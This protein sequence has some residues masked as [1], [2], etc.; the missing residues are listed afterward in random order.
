MDMPLLAELTQASGP[1]GAEDRVR[2]IVRGHLEDTCDRVDDLAMG[3]IDGVRAADGDPT[4]R[5]MLAAHMDEIGLMITHVD[6]RGYAS[7]I[8][9]GG[10]DARTLVGQRV[11]VHGRDDLLGIVG[12]TPVHLLD[13]AARSKAPKM[14]DLTIDLGLPGEQAQDLVRKGDVATRVRDLAT[15][16]HLVSGK[17]LDDR[18]GV[19]VMLQAMRA[20]GPSRMEVHAT[21]TAQEEVGLR[22][23]RT[24]AHRI[25]PDI[26]VAIDT[27]P[28][29]DGPGT[30]KS[31]PSTRLGDG[32]AIRVMDAS[33]IGHRGLVDLLIALAEERDIPHQLHVSNKGGTDT[34]SLQM[35][36]RGAIAGCISI[37][38][39]YVHTAVEA[40]HPDDIDAAVAL[41][42]ALIEQAHRLLAGA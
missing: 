31:G 20:A 27:C 5:L 24:A 16:G 10:W 8:P 9:L 37:P 23:A 7:F 32:A 4:G 28:A 22:G 21:A 26:A 13:E 36:G 30:P 15:V 12:S 35:T 11:L 38:T 1:P 42:A 19:Y 39:R 41:T 17:A 29:D 14:D 33:A 6:D 18:V 3:C 25:A 34:A 40:C 2:A